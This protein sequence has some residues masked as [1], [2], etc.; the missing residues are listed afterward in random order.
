[1]MLSEYTVPGILFIPGVLSAHRI[2][3]VLGVICVLE[4]ILASWIIPLLYR[5]RKI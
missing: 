2:V 4:M 3:S 5:M 1:M